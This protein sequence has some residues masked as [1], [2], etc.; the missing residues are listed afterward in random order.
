MYNLLLNL[1]VPFNFIFL[2]IFQRKDAR[3]ILT[4]SY[5]NHAKRV[6]CAVG[7]INGDNGCTSM[8]LITN[9]KSK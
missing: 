7:T 8:C 9:V 1:F 6:L 4:A 5:E 2:Y 3:I